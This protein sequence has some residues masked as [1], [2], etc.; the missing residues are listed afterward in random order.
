LANADINEV[1]LT[2][3]RAFW[4]GD[5][6]N[7]DKEPFTG[8]LQWLSPSYTRDTNPK[9]W[10][11]EVVDLATL[12]E[13]CAHPTLLFYI[14]GEQSVAFAAELAALPS[15]KEQDKYLIAF[16]KPYFSLLPYYEEGLS[17][18]LPVS[19]LATSWV[20]DEFAGYGSYTT[21]RT[22]LEE[23]DKDIEIMR[24][25]LPGRNIWFAGEHTA[26]FVALGTATVSRI[27]FLMVFRF[28]LPRQS[29]CA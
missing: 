2:F 1:Y 28:L 9:R 13:S 26:P 6:S 8:F 21:F 15:K 27:R 19:C 24:E 7:P 25:G 5:P 11:Q 10:N 16:F 17:D 3:P 23:G 14:F 4:L 12:P 18:C 20:S 22:G 29:F